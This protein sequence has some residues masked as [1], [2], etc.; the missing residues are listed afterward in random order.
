MSASSDGT[1]AFVLPDINREEPLRAARLWRLVP[2]DR[3]LETATRFWSDEDSAPIHGEAL[4]L[5]VKQLKF[6][7]RSVM[8]LPDEKKARYLMS[9]RSLPEAVASRLL[10]VYHLAFQRQMMAAFLDALGIANED[11]VISG[12]LTPPGSAKAAAAA[13]ALK[14]SHPQD[15]VRLYFLT[16]LYQDH[17]SW[18]PLWGEVP[19]SD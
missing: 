3:R 6:R 1:H 2:D 11:G 12:E 14:A 19:T 10:V 7:P 18:E 13:R 17:E 16:L 5:L 8:A 9:I 15:D 4:A